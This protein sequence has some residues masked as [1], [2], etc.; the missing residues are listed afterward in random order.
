[1]KV[2]KIRTLFLIIAAMTAGSVPVLAEPV[3]GPNPP[4]THGE[5]NWD[6]WN[7][8]GTEISILTAKDDPMNISFIVPITVTMLVVEGDGEVKTPS[9][10]AYK[11][12]NASKDVAESPVP[13]D[14]AVTDMKFK[15][16]ENSTY[17]TVESPD[18]SGKDEIWLQ[19]GGLTM[20]ALNSPGQAAEVMITQPPSPFVDSEGKWKAIEPET[21][22]P[23]AA[24]PMNALQLPVK[25]RVSGN[26]ILT[27]D[28]V[29]IQQFQVTY[30]ISP[31]IDGEPLHGDGVYAGDDRE[32]AG[33]PAESA[34]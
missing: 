7:H 32:Q 19:I 12:I 14:I 27:A 25:G 34:K 28:H 8:T 18:V 11:I 15:R 17:K 6:A 9:D 30:I 31:L 4:Y 13:L 26:E 29:P 23:S 2:G 3:K 22:T 5:N 21:A 33:L 16:L 24:S 10:T 20:P 1:M